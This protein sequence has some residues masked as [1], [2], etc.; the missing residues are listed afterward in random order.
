MRF[1][2]IFGHLVVAFLGHRS[3]TKFCGSYSVLFQIC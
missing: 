3:S 2:T 1:N